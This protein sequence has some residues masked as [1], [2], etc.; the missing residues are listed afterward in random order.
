M[1]RH[2]VFF[3]LLLLPGLGLFAQTAAELDRLLET[4]AAGPGTA[5]RFVLGSAGLLPKDLS[6]AAAEKAALLM[7][8]EQGWLR[9]TAAEHISLKETAFLVMN[10]FGLSGGALYSLAHNPRYA[11]RELLYRGLI[12]GRA[13]PDFTVSGPRLLQ[14]IERTMEYIEEKD[15]AAEKPQKGAAAQ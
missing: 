10:A 14:I 15:H 12:Q 5:A 6:G 7:A 13:D 3:L 4:E 8:Q 2:S 11:Y 1:K 9:K